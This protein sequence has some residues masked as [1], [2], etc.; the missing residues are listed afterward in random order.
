MAKVAVFVDHDIIIR[1]FILNGILGCLETDYDVVFIFP[2]SHRRVSTKLD[3]LKLKRYKTVKVAEERAY[4]YRRLYHASV[5]RFLRRTEDK[6]IVFRFWRDAL[7]KRAY[8]ESWLYSWP[9]SYH[10]YRWRML[11]QIG[12]SAELNQMLS[13][14]DPDIIVHPTV[15]EGLFVSDLVQWGKRTGRPTL[16]IMNSWD[17]PATK[18]MMIGYPDRLAVWGEQ[19]R[20][21]AVKHLG[22]PNKNIVCLGASQFDLYRRPP[23]EAPQEFR[24]RIGIPNGLKL[25]LYAGSSKGL[26]ET[27]HL[28]VLETAIEKGELPGCFVLYRPHPWRAQVEDEKDF[29]SMNWRHV[30]LS[31][32]MEASY[33]RSREWKGRVVNPADYEDTHVTLS[34]VDAV[35]SPL[36][37]ILLEAAMHGKPIAAYLPDEDL[38]ENLFLY[39]TANM[40]H[41]KEF[42]ERVECLRCERPGDLIKDCRRLLEQAGA[43]GMSE[44]LKRQCEYFVEP[45][46]FPYGERL[47]QLIR[48]LI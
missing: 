5:L 31:P 38:K 26:N 8:W 37:T 35:I 19:T 2:E 6:K 13:H 33:R 30:I 20:R 45:S 46:P 10:V 9:I 34:A 48:E 16:F 47:K 4:L 36:S 24:R 32:D 40:I 17:N 21:L 41:F 12:E 27:R 43:P 11:S 23:R 14:E 25:L 29:Y 39:T 3:T 22:V 18:A 28:E 44:G 15:L 1:H 7:G 42:F